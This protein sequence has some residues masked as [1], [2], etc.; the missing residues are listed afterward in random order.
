MFWLKNKWGWLIIWTL[1][2]RIGSCACLVES[3]L[4]FIFHWSILSFIFFKV[5]VNIWGTNIF[6]QRVIWVLL[7]KN[8]LK[9]LKVYPVCG[10]ILVCSEN[11]ALH[12]KWSFPLRISSVYVAKSAVLE[13]FLTFT[14]EILNGKLYLLCSVGQSFLKCFRYIKKYS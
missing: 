4:K 7:S 8:L 1:R 10:F 12:K 11:L 13:D 6:N 14:E 9:C 5:Q 3:G 2:E